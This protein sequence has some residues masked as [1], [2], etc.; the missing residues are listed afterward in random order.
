[1]NALT[2]YA[3]PERREIRRWSLASLVVIVLHATLFAAITYWHVSRPPPGTPMPAILIDL[4]PVSASPDQSLQDLAP[5]PTMQQ[6][7]APAAEPEKQQ[8]EETIAPTPPQQNPIVAAPPEPISKPT[9]QPVKPR[10][11][12]E[13]VKKPSEKPPAPKTAA[14][15]RAERQAP[16]QNATT[17]ASAAAATASYNAMVAAHLNRFRQYPAA[18]RAAGETGVA[19]LSFTVGRSGQVLSSRL[20]RSSGHPALDADT[21]ALIRRAQPLPAF[22]P[23]IR[24]ASLNFNV[25]ISYSLR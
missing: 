25:P 1:M 21:M 23:E 2:L 5:G 16:A 7:D 9:P 20:S 13:A 22:P 6:A 4:S 10:P 12:H 11:V 17:G 18:S 8:V 15:P 24:Q 19:M 3:V 14:A